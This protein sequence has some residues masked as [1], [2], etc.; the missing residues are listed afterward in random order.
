MSGSQTVSISVSVRAFKDVCFFKL[1]YATLFTFQLKLIWNC[2]WFDYITF[3]ER[4]PCDSLFLHWEIDAAICANPWG[5]NEQSFTTREWQNIRMVICKTCECPSLI[6]SDLRDHNQHHPE[7]SNFPSWF[8][9][10]T[11]LCTHTNPLICI[12]IQGSP[13]H[14]VV[15][16]E[17]RQDKKRFTYIYLSGI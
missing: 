7:Q 3:K 8:Q 1:W 6:C 5:T 9:W 17:V 11:N 14:T 2:K 15:K 16:W 4:N 12:R 10:Q 13:S